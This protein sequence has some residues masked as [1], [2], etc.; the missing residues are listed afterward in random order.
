MAGATGKEEFYETLRYWARLEL[1]GVVV[2]PNERVS[3]EELGKA[4]L[5]SVVMATELRRES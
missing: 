1:D 3:A 2:R 5:D 4:G